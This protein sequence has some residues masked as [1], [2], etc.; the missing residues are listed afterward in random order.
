MEIHLE[1]GRIKSDSDR[2]KPP[3]LLGPAPLEGHVLDP[4]FD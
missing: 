1:A 4:A 3:F 2:A